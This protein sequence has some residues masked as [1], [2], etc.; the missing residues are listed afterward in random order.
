MAVKCEYPRIIASE[1]ARRVADNCYDIHQFL[2]ELHARGELRTDFN[3]LDIKVG[4]HAPCHLRSLGVTREP[5]ELMQLIPGL[6]VH[7]YSDKCCGMGGTYG[8]KS[9]NYELSMKIGQRLFDEIAS[10]D[11]DQLVTGCGA[12]GM[13][14]RQ[15]TLRE[16]VHP[17]KLL[18]EAYPKETAIHKVA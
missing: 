14:I 5:V 16:S 17:I 13:Q 12:C 2:M 6:T 3:R 18:A 8:L 15:G 9:K 10:S 1:E 7:T 11:V 4:Y